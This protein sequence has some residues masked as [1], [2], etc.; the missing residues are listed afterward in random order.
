MA[1]IA[2]SIYGVICIIGGVI[3]YL[4]AKSTPSLISGSISGI[5]ML[6][7][8]YL[9]TQ[10]LEWA[11]LMAGAITLLLII[12]FSVRLKKTGKFMPAG[13]MIILGVITLVLVL[14]QYFA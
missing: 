7:S 8:S 1:V 2:S 12:V 9:I 11:F 10:G 14:S 6:I 4:Q 5:L 13:L 3:G